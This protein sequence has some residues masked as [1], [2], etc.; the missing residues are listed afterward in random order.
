MNSICIPKSA[1]FPDNDTGHCPGESLVPMSKVR[2]GTPLIINAVD[3]KTTAP[4]TT[5]GIDMANGGWNT[6]Q[7][8][9]RERR[10]CL[11]LAVAGGPQDL[12]LWVLLPMGAEGDTST[13]VWGKYQDVYNVFPKG[14]IGAGVAIGT[15]H[16]I[17]EDVTAFAK[18]FIQKSDAGHDVTGFLHDVIETGNS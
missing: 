8:S 3:V 6:S 1:L 4:G 12:T 7:G 17:L 16:F 11:T 14:I 10:V 2:T 13:D 18:F 15:Y 9:M 5:D